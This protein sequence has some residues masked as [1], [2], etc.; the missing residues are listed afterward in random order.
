[1]WIE[2]YNGHIEIRTT[3]GSCM[4]KARKTTLEEK[5]TIAREYIES[6]RNYGEIANKYK[7]SYHDQE[8]T[9]RRIPEQCI[10]DLIFCHRNSVKF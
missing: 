3:G 7:V 4:T 9:V 2:M 6:G 10:C 1:M 5:I 8:K